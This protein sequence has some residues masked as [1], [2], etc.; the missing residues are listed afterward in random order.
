MLSRHLHLQSFFLSGRRGSTKGSSQHTQR[1][2]GG[3]G[4]VS[5][6][7]PRSRAHRAIPMTGGAEGVAHVFLSEDAGLSWRPIDTLEMPDVAYHAA[8]FETHEPYRLFVAN[9][10]GVWMTEDFAAWTDVSTTLPN[11]IVSDLVYHH[12]D[13]SLTAATYGRGVW[14]VIL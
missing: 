4:M 8:V 5:R 12:R 6:A 13:Q 9:D 1:A 3:M 14:R 2:I 11:V 10:C 7:I